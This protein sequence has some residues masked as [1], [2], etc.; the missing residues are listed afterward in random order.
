M[1]QALH[2]SS[3]G[4]N[5]GQSQINVI[6]HNVA[7]I[8]TTAYKSANMT[9]ETLYSHN[10]SYGSAATKEG[11]GT[12]PKQV[13]LGVKVGGIT[14]NFTPGSFVSTGRN[15]DTMISG[16]GFYVVKDGNG[17]N[18]Y[19]RDGI[20]SVDSA[21][22][23]V[24]QNGMK[25]VAAK[26]IYSNSG[27]DETVQIP[28]NMLAKV[29]GDPDISNRTLSSLNNA[30]IT[31]G[32]VAV[33]VTKTTSNTVDNGDG[34]STTTTV[35]TSATG[36]TTTNVITDN[37]TGDI[38]STTETSA[39]T[40]KLGPFSVNIPGGNGTVGEIV[41]NF[42]SVEGLTAVDNGDGTISYSADSGYTIDFSAE[43]TTSNFLAESGWIN[44]TTS[45]PLSIIATLQDVVNYN[46]PD[47]ISLTDVG[48]DE[49]GIIVA[50][51]NDG[52]ILTQYV[53]ETDSVQWK[54]MTPDGISIIGNDVIAE[55]SSIK[56]ASFSIELATMVNQEGLISVNNNLWKWGPNAG[57]IYY[58]MAGEMSFG[59][60]ES[61]GYE[62]SNV[63]IASELSNM[64]MAQRM[65]QMNSRVFSTAS[66]VMQQLAYLGQ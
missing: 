20:F 31:E 14:R 43:G 62:E 56:N 30:S 65:I 9:F 66:E 27:S 2:T 32:T 26:S 58:G 51:Y 47:T 63:D 53:D 19:T 7:N 16:N 18:Y 38:I 45:N 33:L 6:A 22:N 61:G 41:A 39:A 42:N 40:P 64:I 23:L 57:E 29:Q 10:L 3:T 50:T 48:I 46:S 8:N 59:T 25:V 12:N 37:T 34:T 55:G 5:S 24:T 28:K 15:L 4:I 54:Y 44:S 52:S 13:G 60:I 35:V 11:G 17:T 1:S 21:G 36:T 49:N